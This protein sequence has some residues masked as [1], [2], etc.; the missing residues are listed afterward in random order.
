MEVRRF[1]REVHDFAHVVEILRSARILRIA[2][3]DADGLTIVPVTFCVRDKDERLC[4]YLHGAKSGRKY[5][6]FHG[7]LAVAFEAEGERRAIVKDIPCNNSW[8]YSSVVGEGRIDEVLEDNEKAAALT[9]LV[10]EHAAEHA[11]PVT[12]KMAAS[13]AVFRLDVT[14]YRCKERRF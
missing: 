8:I 4:F 2:Y 11:A 12:P 13:T 14:S 9:W 3:Q 6:A 7:G 1:D 5:E 10:Q